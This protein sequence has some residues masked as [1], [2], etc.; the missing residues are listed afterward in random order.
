[1]VSYEAAIRRVQNNMKKRPTPGQARES[2][3]SCGILNSDYQVAEAYKDIVVKAVGI[4]SI[5]YSSE[6]ADII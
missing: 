4:S 3:K 6:D 5:E 2:L 1:M